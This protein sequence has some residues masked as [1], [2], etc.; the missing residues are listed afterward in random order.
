MCCCL[1]VCILIVVEALLICLFFVISLLLQFLFLF[2]L[3]RALEDEGKLYGKYIFTGRGARSE[4]GLSWSHLAEVSKSAFSQRKCSPFLCYWSVGFTLS[5][6]SR[7]W[8][9]RTVRRA[10]ELLHYCEPC[11][12]LE[13]LSSPRVFLCVMLQKW[14]VFY[15]EMEIVCML[16]WRSCWVVAVVLRYQKEV[17][18]NWK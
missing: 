15:V 1:F 9:V 8:E 11:V 7:V 12:Y 3:L 13:A 17:I 14:P 2:F 16:L 6:E 10:C 4:A 18:F 5:E